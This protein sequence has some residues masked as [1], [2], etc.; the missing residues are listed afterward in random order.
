MAPITQE[1]LAFLASHRL[2]SSVQRLVIEIRNLNKAAIALSFAALAMFWVSY[3]VSFWLT[4]SEEMRSLSALISHFVWA[5]AISF[6]FFAILLPRMFIRPL[7]A[8][9]SCALELELQ[10]IGRRSYPETVEEWIALD[11]PWVK[12]KSEGYDCVFIGKV[13][14]WNEAELLCA[15]RVINNIVKRRVSRR[16]SVHLRPCPECSQDDE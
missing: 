10:Q 3:A 8:S 9:T 14:D 1:P 12:R 15:S 16:C 7:P 11:T 5:I 2:D 6:A 13:Y 4:A